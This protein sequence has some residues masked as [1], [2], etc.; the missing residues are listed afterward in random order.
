MTKEERLLRE[1]FGEDPDASEPEK[2]WL[3]GE[4]KLGREKSFESH[5]TV[6]RLKQLIADRPDDSPVFIERVSDWYFEPERGWQETSVFKNLGEG[7]LQQFV[8]AYWAV[9]MK[10]DDAVY[11]TPHY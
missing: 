5:L 9:C 7:H 6:G 4:T 2:V 10:D 8:Q 11:I 3:E 1:I